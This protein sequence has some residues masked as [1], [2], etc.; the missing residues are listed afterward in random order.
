MHYIILIYGDEKNFA[1]MSED[2]KAKEEMYAAFMR[3]G[4]D[5]QAAG[6]LRGGAELKPTHSATT[7]RVRNGRMVTTDGPFAETK[8]Q[9]GG[10]Y[11]IDAKDLDEALGWAKMLPVRDRS[12]EVRPVMDYEARGAQG[13]PSEKAAAHS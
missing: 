2:P 10:Y 13:P 12:I 1:M 5:M 9:L 7:V 11:L 3:Y 8:E 4:A 6:V